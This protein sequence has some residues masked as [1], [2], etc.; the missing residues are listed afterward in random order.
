MSQSDAVSGQTETSGSPGGRT[1]GD[2][3]AD[4]ALAR[5]E[6]QLGWYDRRATS[7]QRWFAISK[8]LSLVAAAAIPV[9]SGF[10]ERWVGI[11]VTLSVSL[12]GAAIVVIEGLLRHVQWEQHWLRYRAI[13][14]RSP[15]LAEAFARPGSL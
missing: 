13:P 4:P 15:L 2:V 6:S 1:A 3:Q 10:G 12:L 5:L 9:L 11:D 7:S 14:T 8:V